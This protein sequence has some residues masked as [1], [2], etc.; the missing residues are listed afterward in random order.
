MRSQNVGEYRG[1]L[2]GGATQIE[3]GLRDIVQTVE[4]ALRDPTPTTWIGVGA[5][6]FVLWF[7]FI[8]RKR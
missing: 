2:D 7:I 5:F 8:R 6:F 3:T 4:D 1:L